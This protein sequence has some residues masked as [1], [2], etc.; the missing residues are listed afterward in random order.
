[1]TLK[2][3]QKGF[4]HCSSRIVKYGSDPLFSWHEFDLDLQKKNLWTPEKVI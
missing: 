2:Q 3:K 4:I 1:M